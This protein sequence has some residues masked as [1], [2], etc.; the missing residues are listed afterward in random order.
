MPSIG[1]WV[2]TWLLSFVEGENHALV[3]MEPAAAQK[4]ELIP[5]TYGIDVWGKDGG[6]NGEQYQHPAEAQ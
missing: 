1:L 5:A 6:M 4:R 2:C 3:T